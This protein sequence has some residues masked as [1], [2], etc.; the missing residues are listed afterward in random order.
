MENIRETR[1]VADRY[2]I[3]CSLML[4]D[5]QKCTLLKK[6]KDYKDKTIREI[7]ME[8]FSY[9]DGCTVSAKKDGLVNIGGF[10]ALNDEKLYR[11]ASQVVVAY[12]G[13][14]TYGGLAGRDMEA[15]ARGLQEVVEK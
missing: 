15:L 14:P 7:A 3:P 10:I 6:G 11:L 2:G 9:G 13:F 5:L 1:E 12:E 4:L 8:M